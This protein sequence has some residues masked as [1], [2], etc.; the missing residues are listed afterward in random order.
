MSVTSTSPCLVALMFPS[1][2]VGK[3]IV[4]VCLIFFHT[5]PIRS[6]G[7]D[8]LLTAA[9][10]L[11]HIMSS[12]RCQSCQGCCHSCLQMESTDADD[13]HI[14]HYSAVYLYFHPHFVAVDGKGGLNKLHLCVW[15]SLGLYVYASKCIHSLR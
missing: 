10:L 6:A 11:N 14:V 4:F 1:G 15:I 8:D 7:C 3:G 13:I 9:L 12:I 2:S 5:T